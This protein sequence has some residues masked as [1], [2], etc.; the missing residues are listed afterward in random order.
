MSEYRLDGVTIYNEDD[1]EVVSETMAYASY[2]EMLDTYG[3][4]KIGNITLDASRV[5]KEC[6]P[7]AYRVGFS[8][9]CDGQEWEVVEDNK[10]EDLK[11]QLEQDSE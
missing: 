6:D 11:E 5:L 10:L 7:I 8:D 4:I 1:Y 2:D 9:Y 3:E